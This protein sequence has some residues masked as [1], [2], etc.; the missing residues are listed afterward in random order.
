MINHVTCHD[1]QDPILTAY[2]LL[3]SGVKQSSENFI[4]IDQNSIS[5]QSLGNEVQKILCYQNIH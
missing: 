4:S 3:E 5:A 2:A 1:M